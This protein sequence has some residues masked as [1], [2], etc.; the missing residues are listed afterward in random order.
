MRGRDDVEQALRRHDA[1][2]QQAA[3]G[4]VERSEL[5]V[6]GGV[7]PGASGREDRDAKIGDAV[8]DGEA[9][10]ELAA[11]GRLQEGRGGDLVGVER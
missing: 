8:D 10:E 5:A 6:D 4:E 9:L 11:L 3:G 7:L 2:P 1:P